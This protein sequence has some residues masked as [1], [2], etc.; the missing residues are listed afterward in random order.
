MIKITLEDIN[1][2]SPYE[3]S[4][5]NGDFDFT[6]DSGTRYSVS[7]LEDVPLG[8]CDTY[9]FGFRKR[10]DTHS[11]YDVHVK[12][13]LIAIIEQFFAENSNVLLYICDTSDGREAKRNRLFVRWFEEFATPDRF[14]METANATV[15]GQGFY[16]AIIVERTNPLLEAIVCDFKQ[17]AESLT[18]GKP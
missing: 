4:L 9:Q 12:D 8:G 15:E 1:Q 13:T 6:T 3:I 18:D 7:F 2:K 16:A 17:T 10:E 14:I 11:G 5:N